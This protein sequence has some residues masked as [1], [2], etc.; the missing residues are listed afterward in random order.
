MPD[1][2]NAKGYYQLF[3]KSKNK[4]LVKLSKKIIQQP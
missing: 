2:S 1:A 4:K 3:L